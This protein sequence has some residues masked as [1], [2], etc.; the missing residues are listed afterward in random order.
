[1]NPSIQVVIAFT[2]FG[3]LWCCKEAGRQPS[4][5]MARKADHPDSPL[6]LLETMG[7]RLP[8]DNDVPFVFAPI[9]DN[10][11][12]EVLLLHMKQTGISLAL[13][14]SIDLGNGLWKIAPEDL[15]RGRAVVEGHHLKE[16]LKG[17]HFE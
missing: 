1:M 14:D 17:F 5:P 10:A 11:P 16:S 12:L 3:G 4:A 8:R 7:G 15:E 9:D 13:P 6:A 2:L